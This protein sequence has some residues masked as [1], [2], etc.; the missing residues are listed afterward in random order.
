VT[1]GVFRTHRSLRGKALF[2]LTKLLFLL[3]FAAAQLCPDWSESVTVGVIDPHFLPEAS[4]IAVS[5]QFPDRLYHVND[6]GDEPYFYITDLQGGNT[7]PVRVEGFRPHDVEDLSLGPCWGA[8]CPF[9]GDIGDNLKRRQEVEVIM[10]EEADFGEAARPLAR[11]TLEYPDG[12]HNAEALAVHPNGDLYLLTKEF[13]SEWRVPPARLYRLERARLHAGGRQA[14]EFVGELDLRLLSA[15]PLDLLSH[16]VTAMDIFHDGGSFLV[17]TYGHAYE[18]AIDLQE[19]LG[20][21]EAFEEGV[22]YNVIRIRRLPQ[23]ESIAYSGEGSFFYST[24]LRG[25]VAELV[26]VD[27]LDG[28]R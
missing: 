19:G 6:S 8:T 16:I 1:R 23:Q 4:G 26:R 2:P 14:L 17:L 27:C 7:R 21:S 15:F 11:V 3:S 13:V 25:Q 10:I 5:R 28:V 12:P 20:P 22:D 24:E 18:F 9:I